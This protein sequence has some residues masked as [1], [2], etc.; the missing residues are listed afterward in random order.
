MASVWLAFAAPPAG[1]LR[2][3]SWTGRQ[4]AV[5]LSLTTAPAGC[6][7]PPPPSA[8]AGPPQRRAGGNS[9]GGD[10]GGGS[11]GGGGSGGRGF[12]VPPFSSSP[13]PPSSPATPTHPPPADPAAWA[14]AYKAY[15]GRNGRV[16][17]A[18]CYEGYTT[19]GRGA[20]FAD[21]T[22][23][24]TP[25][26]GGREVGAGSGDAV[27]QLESIPS[28]YVTLEELIANAGAALSGSGSS[29]G[30]GGGVAGRE[31]A[32]FAEI[33]DRVR[34]YDPEVE[35]CVIFQAGGVMGVD[36]VRPSIAPRV[37][38][39]AGREPGGG[40]RRPGGSG[41]GQGGSGMG[42]GEGSKPG[43]HDGGRGAL[44]EVVDVASRE[45]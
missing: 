35:F 7:R 5:P 45:A 22:N 13:P 29:G 40:P 15:I 20:V 21:Y 37:V 28:M 6:R 9:G 19:R 30:G 2:R 18:M 31:A 12:G 32:D 39:E 11:V 16:A 24:P 10:D 44:H 26:R 25:G 42:Q 1:T 4:V 43:S 8:R 36:V 34:G 14:A 38:W 3:G 27:E 17:C 41:L 33:V 23:A